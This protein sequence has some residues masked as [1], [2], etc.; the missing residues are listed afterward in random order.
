VVGSDSH[1]ETNSFFGLS[2]GY[3]ALEK[4]GVGEITIFEKR[5]KLKIPLVKE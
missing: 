5:K 2:D 3:A 4:L 1:S